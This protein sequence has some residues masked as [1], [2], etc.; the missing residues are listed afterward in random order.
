MRLPVKGQVSAGGEWWW[1]L[2]LTEPDARVLASELRAVI[3]RYQA[4]A[5]AGGK[6]FTGY[7]ALAPV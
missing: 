5:R 2:N 7:L 3:A 6:A 1:R 4:S